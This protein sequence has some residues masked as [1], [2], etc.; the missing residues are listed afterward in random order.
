MPELF[1]LHLSAQGLYAGGCIYI[2]LVEMPA[3]RSCAIHERKAVLLRALPKAG[4]LMLP[5]LLADIVAS[6]VWW[7]SDKHLIYGVVNLLLMVAVLWVTL[8]YNVPINRQLLSSEETESQGLWSDKLKLWAN[9]HL[10]RT[11]FAVSAYATSIF[12]I[13]LSIS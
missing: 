9:A 8:I 11:V 7:L 13:T 10:T 3:I 1:F 6:I 5:L 12:A 4:M 2:L